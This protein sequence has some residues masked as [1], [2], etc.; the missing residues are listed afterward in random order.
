M[1]LTVHCV[2]YRIFQVCFS[3]FWH[4]V[5]LWW[6]WGCL[7]VSPTTAVRGLRDAVRKFVLNS[8][9]LSLCG[10]LAWFHTHWSLRALGPKERV[11]LTPRRPPKLPLH[12]CP[13]SVANPLTA[14]QKYTICLI[15]K[16][17]QRHEHC[18]W[19]SAWEKNLQVNKWMR[20]WKTQTGLE[21]M[22]ACVQ[23]LLVDLHFPT[24]V[25][26]D[27]PKD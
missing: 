17:L 15:L 23:T 8:H 27:F 7:E 16:E 1:P 4:F 9:F 3:C 24:P 10:E 6:S 26:S 19:K 12:S 20:W 2:R 14:I 11:S 21:N 25:K 13:A 18:P 22:R 5:V